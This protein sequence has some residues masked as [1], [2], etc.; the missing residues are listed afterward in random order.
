M[1]I[2]IKVD[3]NFDKN[4]FDILGEAR[5]TKFTRDIYNELRQCDIA[6]K[7]LHPVLFRAYQVLIK[8]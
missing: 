8:A 3:F 2:T 6:K 1:K 7:R 4:L 5:F